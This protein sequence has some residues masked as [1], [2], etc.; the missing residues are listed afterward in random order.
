ML[1]IER[2][3]TA[4]A[5]WYDMQSYGAPG[6]YAQLAIAEIQI[7]SLGPG[8]VHGPSSGAT[9]VTGSQWHSSAEGKRS[10]TACLSAL[11]P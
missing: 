9:L 2:W 7:Q 5:S 6:A 10:G 1:G 11:V 4:V 3:F 8:R